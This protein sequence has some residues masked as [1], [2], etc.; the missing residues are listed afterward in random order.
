M[1]VSKNGHFMNNKMN[2]T[3]LKWFIYG[4]G[5]IINELYQH[6]FTFIVTH[7][8]PL[9]ILTI[10]NVLFTISSVQIINNKIAQIYSDKNML[11]LYVLRIYNMK[12]VVHNLIIKFTTAFSYT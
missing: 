1:S 3:A 5:V 12:Q 2:K 11:T 7:Y 4:H 10:R 8:T 9:S 6:T